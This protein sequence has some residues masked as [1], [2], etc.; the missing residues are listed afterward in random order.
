MLLKDKYK[1]TKIEDLQH[2]TCYNI[3]YSL[4]DK[5]H[6]SI[7]LY[8]KN[9][10]GKTLI[11]NILQKTFDSK[12]IITEID[13]YTTKHNILLI[14]DLDLI[15]EKEQ[16]KIKKFLEKGGSLVSTISNPYKIIKDIIIR[17]IKVEL[18]INN[19]YYKN[20]LNYIIEQEGISLYNTCVK[21]ILI[22]SNYNIAIAINYIQKLSIIKMDYEIIIHNTTWNKYYTLCLN[23][24]KTSVQELLN[25]II[26]KDYSFIDLLHSF[27]QYIKY[28]TEIN[29]GI[30]YKIIKLILYYIPIY[31][32]IQN[33]CILL[34]IFTNR[35][36]NLLQ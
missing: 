34:Y 9:N 14:D 19:M 20:H 22:Q 12:Y 13:N 4:K 23:N 11:L 35:L 28:T 7:L 33:N 24:D 30:K 2:Y 15:T 36:I 10:I 27:L 3:L 18:S 25:T 17:S 8:G 32:K 29:D 31:Y 5:H 21:D 16:F 1:P 6:F 26:D